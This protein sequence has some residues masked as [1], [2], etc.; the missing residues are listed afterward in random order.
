MRGHPVALLLCLA[1][2]LGFAAAGLGQD[3]PANKAARIR[4]LDFRLETEVAGSEAPKGK[5]FL[6]LRTEWENIHPKQ[7]VK[8]SDRAFALLRG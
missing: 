8:K 4:I 3:G 7:K 6:T 2:I 5:V 1:F